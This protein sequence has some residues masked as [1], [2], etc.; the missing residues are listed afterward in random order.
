M[1]VHLTCL[2]R[3]K[4]CLKYFSNRSRRLQHQRSVL[5]ADEQSFIIDSIA[6]LKKSVSLPEKLV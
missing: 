6:S 1:V 3:R 2:E 4:L 5:F